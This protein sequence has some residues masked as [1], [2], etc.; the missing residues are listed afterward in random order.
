MVTIALAEDHPVYRRGLVEI[1]KLH[2]D[3]DVV[4]EAENGLDLLEKLA[5]CDTLPK[6]V[7]LDIKMPK[8]NGYE[9]LKILRK[10][11]PSI[12]VIAL[13][14]YD[15]EF[16]IM[17][18][19]LNGASG[20]IAKGGDPK[21]LFETIRQVSENGRYYSEKILDYL[22]TGK[23]NLQK[24]FPELSKREMEFLKYCQL[25][26]TY[27]QIAQ[28]MGVA[29]RSVENYRVSLFKKL[30]IH[31]RSSLTSFAIKSGLTD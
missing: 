12:K 18:M 7:L 6:I 9:T 19:I 1:F 30:G 2:K 21:K 31:N 23:Y 14:V 22:S 25:D 29:E 13:S 17:S 24:R 28:E 4:V 3:I 8:L 16:P 27:K 20:H 5:K 15:D 10:E 11:Y 26:M